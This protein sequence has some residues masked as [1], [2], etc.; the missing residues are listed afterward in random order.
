[1]LFTTPQ[2]DEEEQ[3]VLDKIDQIRKSLSYMI[4]TPSKWYGLLRRS[5]FAKN[6]QA[7]NSIEGINVSVED[8]LAAVDNQDPTDATGDNWR[9]IVGYRTAMTY[10]LQLATDPYFTYNNGLIR[11]LHYMILSYDLTKHPGCWRPG[12]IFVRAQQTGE[13]VYEGP[14]AEIVPKLMEELVVSLQTDDKSVSA[15]IRAAMGHLNLAMIHPFSDGNGR[16]ARCLQTLILAR[17][18]ILHPS[19]CSIEENLGRNTAEYYAV[20]A[21][22]GQGNW[23]PENNSKPWIRFCLTA[24]YKQAQTFLWRMREI[25]RV[26]EEVEREIQ[27][28]GLHERMIAPIVEAAF[29]RLI[30]RSAYCALAENISEVVASRDLKQLV[31]A[32]YLIPIGEKRGRVY[33]ASPMILGIRTRAREE[34]KY[35]EPFR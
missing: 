19:F 1:M 32:T 17:E 13:N 16:M 33:R 29:G 18:G 3:D 15:T 7:S 21:E 20:L 10:V 2:I 28:R 25:Q 6:I 35:I 30:R 31:D 5:T 34:R 26:W 22:V 11:S 9:A 14:E 23:H 27:L 12:S 8:A 4:A 24:H